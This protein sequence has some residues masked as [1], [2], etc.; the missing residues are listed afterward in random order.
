[1][2]LFSH[3]WRDTIKTQVPSPL[4]STTEMNKGIYERKKKWSL[5][6]K[7]FSGS[8]SPPLRCISNVAARSQRA[9]MLRLYDQ[10][11]LHFGLNFHFWDNSLWLKP[12]VKMSSFSFHKCSLLFTSGSSLFLELPA[13][14]YLGKFIWPPISQRNKIIRVAPSHHD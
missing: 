4:P 9:G 1:M 11:W 3:Q 14:L 13:S 2:N 7:F 5:E 6:F 8:I 12:K 10:C